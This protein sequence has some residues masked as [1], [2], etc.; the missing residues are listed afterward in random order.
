[1]KTT[2]IATG[3]SFTTRRISKNAP[4]YRELVE[5]LTAHDVRFN[6][7]EMTYHDEEGFPSAF[8]GGTWAMADPLIL[9]DLREM[10]LNLYNTANNHSMDYCH[11]GLMATVRNL[12]RRGMTF[13]GT[14]ESLAAASR[15]AYL[16]TGALRVALIGVTSDFHDSD[17]AGEQGPV[18]SGRPGVNGLRVDRIIHVTEDY[19]SKLR[20]LVRETNLNA[21][22]EYGIKLGYVTPG[23]EDVLSMDGLRFARAER[24]FIEE[25]PNRLDMERTI[26]EIQEARRQADYVMVSIHTHAGDYADYSAPPKF[27]EIFARRCIDAGADVILGHGP[28]EL[29]GI[30]IYSGKPIF[31]SLGNFI[32]QTET[33]AKQPAEAYLKKG[34]SPDTKVG[35]YMEERSQ[36]GAR[37]YGT[38][39]PVWFSVMPSWAVEDGV[40]RE[41]RLYPISLGMDLPRSQK[42][43][44]RLVRDPSILEHLQRLSE[45]YGTKIC[46]Q[47][48]AGVIALAD[49]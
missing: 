21:Y 18:L 16:E 11:G 8:S 2:F 41:L 4:G 10:G 35:A 14:G 24:V 46:V 25:R 42:G 9:D 17:L 31:Y 20:E 38:L 19:F 3:D 34:F 7:L 45:P 32:F 22:E 36:H 13:A 6:N 43:T 47:D 29:R 1:M 26:A 15:A 27:M 30:E 23:A 12:R 48:G 44:P 37:G 28:H 49:S 33:V 40:V 5:L 39:P